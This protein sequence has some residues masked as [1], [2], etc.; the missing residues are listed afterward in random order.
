MSAGKRIL[1]VV[2]FFAI[3]VGA[4]NR[5]EPPAAV[6]PPVTVEPLLLSPTPLECTENPP[7]LELQ[8]DSLGSRRIIVRGEGFQPG[9]ELALVFTA[10]ADAPTGHNELRHEVRPAQT[11]GEDGSFTWEQT[12]QP[13]DGNTAWDLAVVHVQGGA[14]VTFSAP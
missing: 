12:M 7:G 2:G 1:I 10:Q 5:P 4:C 11:V 8:V 3:M 14:C 13:L 6:E 9:E